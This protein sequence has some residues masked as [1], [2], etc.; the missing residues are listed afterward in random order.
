MVVVL[1]AEV[2]GACW[3]SYTGRLVYR[4]E[5]AMHGRVVSRRVQ[6]RDSRCCTVW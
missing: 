3:W 4:S 1:Q 6:R 2:S 5:A